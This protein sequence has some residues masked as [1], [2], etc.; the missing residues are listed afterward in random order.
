MPVSLEGV[1]LFVALVLVIGAILV[2]YN[3]SPLRE[4]RGKADEPFDPEKIRQGV[5]R[6]HLE[7]VKKALHDDLALNT[8]AELEKAY[9]LRLIMPNQYKDALERLENYEGLTYGKIAKLSEDDWITNAR[10]S[11]L[12]GK[13]KPRQSKFS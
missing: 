12:F 10:A 5:I 9:R 2:R 3:N 11:E 8:V 6:L 7:S 4:P 13:V 1:L